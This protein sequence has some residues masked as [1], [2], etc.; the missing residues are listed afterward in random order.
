MCTIIL[1]LK[2][3][4][5]NKMLT[6]RVTGNVGKVQCLSIQVSVVS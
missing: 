5:Q 4:R 1:L 2:F 3:N 6:V